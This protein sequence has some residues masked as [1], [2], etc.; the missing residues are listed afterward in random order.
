MEEFF[1]PFVITLV[2]FV[3]LITLVAVFLCRPR[4][5]PCPCCGLQCMCVICECGTN[6]AVNSI[7]QDQVITTLT[8]DRI[9]TISLPS[10]MKPDS[11]LLRHMDG[12]LCPSLQSSDKCKRCQCRGYSNEQRTTLSEKKG[13]QIIA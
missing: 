9:A 11:S 13:H 4:K 12:D 5:Q 7:S 3:I 6:K 10:S 2:I 8:S 1:V